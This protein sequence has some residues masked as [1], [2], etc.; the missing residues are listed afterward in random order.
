MDQSGSLPVSLHKLLTPPTHETHQALQIHHSNL[1]SPS[2]PFSSQTSPTSSLYSNNIPF[3]NN[4]TNPLLNLPGLA[5]LIAAHTIILSLLLYQD[6]K[7]LARIR[8]TNPRHGI[9]LD[10]K[11]SVGYFLVLVQLVI[12]LIALG[13]VLSACEIGVWWVKWGGRFVY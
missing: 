13:G 4:I 10:F 12:S 5:V 8:K 11:G 6:V 3:L 2:S 7:R 1:T 9:L